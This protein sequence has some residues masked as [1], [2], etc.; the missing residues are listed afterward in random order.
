M[1]ILRMALL[2]FLFISAVSCK[3]SDMKVTMG[4]VENFKEG[5]LLDLPKGTSKN[6]VASYLS[7]KNISATYLDKEKVFY[8]SIPKIGRYRLI[9]VTSLFIQIRLDESECLESI[10]FELQ[11][12]GP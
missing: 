8:A 2:F 7:R 11:H 4:N 10:E 6:E 1:I 3:A 12:D 9:Y 5:F